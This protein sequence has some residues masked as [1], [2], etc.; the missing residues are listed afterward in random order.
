MNGPSLCP[1][2]HQAVT[3]RAQSAAGRPTRSAP[4][5]RTRLPCSKTGTAL[6]TAAPASTAA[7]EAC[8]TVMLTHLHTALPLGG[9]NGHIKMQ[10]KDERIMDKA[11]ASLREK[12]STH[13]FASSGGG[14]HSNGGGRSLAG[15]SGDAG[16]FGARGSNGGEGLFGLVL[17][18]LPCRAKTKPAELFR[19]VG[20]CKNQAANWCLSRT[21]EHSE[22]L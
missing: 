7:V 22:A 5:A 21:N 3:R 8:A 2:P 15:C 18:F 16:W 17:L 6:P 9:F 19:R 10:M 20:K 12:S 1:P 13:T 14:Q 4:R 11:V